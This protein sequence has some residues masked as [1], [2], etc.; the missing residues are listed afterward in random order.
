V[1][2]VGKY[3]L[4]HFDGCLLGAEFVQEDTS[5]FGGKAFDQFEGIGRAE[6][7]DPL[8]DIVVIDRLSD[9]VQFTCAGEIT[10]HFHANEKT[11]RL[12]TFVVRNSNFAE[13]AEVFDGDRIHFND[14]E[15]DR[16][17]AG[18]RTV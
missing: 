2:S 3:E 6:L 10:G 11:L 14:G 17:W 9:V 5:N 16:G 7:R 18:R 1:A 13:D 12:G 15:H 8:G 4:L